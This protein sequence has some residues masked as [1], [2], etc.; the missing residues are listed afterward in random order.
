MITPIE[1]FDYKCMAVEPQR[2]WEVLVDVK[3]A[4]QW[5]PKSLRL[6]VRHV[7]PEILGSIYEI[8]PQGGQPFSCKIVAVEPIQSIQ[9]EYLGGFIQGKGLWH[10]EPDPIGCKVSYTM[11]VTASG[12]LVAIIG[13]FVS[14]S[15]IHSRQMA[16]VLDNLEVEAKKN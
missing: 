2:V 15:K 13:K 1:A 10:I 14:L 3:R 6:K 8:H 12:I 16:K 11:N 7:A 9:T 5:W 4:E